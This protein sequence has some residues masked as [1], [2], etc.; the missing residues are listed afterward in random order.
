M[1]LKGVRI[2][3]FS[4]YLPGPYAALRLADMGAEVIKIEPP[5]GDP[6]RSLA[7]GYVFTANNRNKQSVTIDFRNK[8]DRKKLL[9]LIPTADIIIESFRPGVMEKWGLHY[10]RVKAL[11]HHIIYCSITGY[12][13]DNSNRHL[14]SH[15]LNYLSLS[16]LLLQLKNDN[17]KPVHPTFPLADYL[18][19]LVACERIIAALYER[20]RTGMGSYLDISILDSVLSLL[21]THIAFYEELHRTNGIPFIDG[22][23][24]SYGIYETKDGRYVSLAALEEKFWKNF[25]EAINKPEWIPYHLSVRTEKNPIYIEIKNVFASRSWEEWLQF[26]TSVDC[27]LTPI[28]DLPDVLQHSY[29]YERQLVEQTSN[30]RTVMKTHRHAQYKP[31]PKLNQNK[32]SFHLLR[33]DESK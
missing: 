18:G 31:A 5:T 22:S 23:I 12:G 33:E 3:D 17:G 28:F 29:L 15:D 13:Q 24:V 4:T 11:N 8:D 10:N 14:G 20:E 21:G 7:G 26:S 6:A 2:L 1:M 16:G 27:C 30:G 25:C 19:S 32:L 9:S